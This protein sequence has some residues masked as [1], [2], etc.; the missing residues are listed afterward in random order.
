MEKA[1]LAALEPF[2]TP[3][4]SFDLPVAIC[5]EIVGIANPYTGSFLPE[6]I[7]YQCS[8]QTPRLPFPF[9]KFL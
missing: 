4:A 6:T 7:K 2:I 3:L 1:I 5:S 8:I 9:P